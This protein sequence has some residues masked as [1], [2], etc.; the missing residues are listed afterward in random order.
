M[1]L[2]KDVVYGCAVI[3]LI[4]DTIV[5]FSIVIYNGLSEVSQLET[6]G[7]GLFSMMM[8]A[9]IVIAKPIKNYI[10]GVIRDIKREVRNKKIDRQIKKVKKEE[11]KK[12][13]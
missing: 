2:F 7:W 9:A 11:S 1:K 3:A 12:A 6:S 8:C 5:Y 4:V 10:N 13:A